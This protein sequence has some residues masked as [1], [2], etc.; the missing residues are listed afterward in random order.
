MDSL[1]QT[2]EASLFSGGQ[3]DDAPNQSA[4]IQLITM[5]MLPSEMVL[6]FVRPA[7]PTLSLSLSLSVALL[8]FVSLLSSSLC[9]APVRLSLALSSF[10]SAQVIVFTSPLLLSPALIPQQRFN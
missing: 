2:V 4:L 1:Y 9:D 5:V 8:L 10:H 6:G 3:S 7:R